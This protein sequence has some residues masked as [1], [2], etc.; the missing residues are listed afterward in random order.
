MLWGSQEWNRSN[1]QHTGT[2]NNERHT[3]YATFRQHTQNNTYIHTIQNHPTTQPQCP[4][5]DGTRLIPW[6]YGHRNGIW[7]YPSHPIRMWIIGRVS[8][9]PRTS[10]V[11]HPLNGEICRVLIYSYIPTNPSPYIPCPHSL[12]YRYH[13]QHHR[14]NNRKSNPFKY[15]ANIIRSKEEEGILLLPLLVLLLLLLLTYTSHTILPWWIL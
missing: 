2:T 11:T 12:P 10:I 8:I 3:K 13:I 5:R 1:H 15:D 6:K 14:N 7:N 4:D 9:G